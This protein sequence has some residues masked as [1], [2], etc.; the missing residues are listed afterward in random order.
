MRRKWLKQPVNDFGRNPGSGV[1]HFGDDLFSILPK[2]QA[3]AA[4]AG[5]HVHGIVEQIE[6]DPAQAAWFQ[7]ELDGRRLVLRFDAH[8]FDPGLRTQLGQQLADELAVVG[9]G[10]RRLGGGTLR[11]LQDVA[12]HLLDVLDLNVNVTERLRVFLR[13]EA[14]AFQRLG[15]QADDGERIF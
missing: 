10:K 7:P 5:H 9:G 15:G 13:G 2:T 12:N 11:K 1:L 3:Q 14:G 8:G 4:A 6:K